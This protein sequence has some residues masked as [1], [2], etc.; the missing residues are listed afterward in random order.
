MS[1]MKDRSVY[2]GI[3]EPLSLE[4]PKELDIKLTD[5]LQKTLVQYGLYDS[6]ERAKQRYNCSPLFL[7]TYI[8]L[9]NMYLSL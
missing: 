3:T 1:E 4:K 9:E 8:I 7:L 5:E 6:K 2:P